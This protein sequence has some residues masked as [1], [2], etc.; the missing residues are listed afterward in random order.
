[1]SISLA[2]LEI[3]EKKTD[4]AAHW[5]REPLGSEPSFWSPSEE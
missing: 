3:S 2:H 1:M 4:R 5:L